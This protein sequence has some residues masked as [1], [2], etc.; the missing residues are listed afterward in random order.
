MPDATGVPLS[1]RVTAVSAGKPAPLA[2][3]V[4]FW[5]QLAEP[6]E[7]PLPTA[8][9]LVVATVGATAAFLKVTPAR[10]EVLFT[11][12]WHTGPG[13]PLQAKKDLCHA[14]PGDGCAV[15][16]ASSDVGTETRQ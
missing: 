9:G 14:S 4:S 7:V 5:A 2:V 12:T 10:S 6:A 8:I 13:A 11:S 3:T 1:D 15:T 16:S